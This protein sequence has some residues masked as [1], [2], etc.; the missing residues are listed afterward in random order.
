[1]IVLT[2]AVSCYIV[3]RQ[4]IMGGDDVISD[5][6]AFLRRLQEMKREGRRDNDLELENRQIKE[7]F[8]HQVHPTEPLRKANGFGSRSQHKP[9]QIDITDLSKKILDN[10]QNVNGTSQVSQVPDLER[11]AHGYVTLPTLQDALRIFSYEDVSFDKYSL[12][13]PVSQ[14][15]PLYRPLTELRPDICMKLRYTLKNAQVSIVV[16][17][18]N[19]MWAVLLRTIHSILMRSPPDLLLEI[20]M[21]DDNSNFD[22]LR[23]PLERYTQ[24][25]PK[26][27][28]VRLRNREGLMRARMAGA[29]LARGD[30]I[31]FLDAHVEC[32]HG[33]LEPLVDRI[34]TDRNILAVPLVNSIDPNTFDYTYVPV[35]SQGTFSWELDYVWKDKLV[36]YE[37]IGVAPH[38]TATMTGCAFAV[39]KETFFRFGGFDEGMDIWGGEQIEISFR[40]WMCGGS[41]EIVPCSHV[42][43]IY[44]AHLPYAFTSGILYK[45]Q[46]RVAEVWMDDFKRYYYYTIPFNPMIFS[47]SELRSI[48]ER[49]R[50]RHKLHCKPFSWY[51]NH[52]A[53]EVEVPPT[54]ASLFGQ[55]KSVG[56]GMCVSQFTKTHFTRF[57][58]IGVDHCSLHL[59]SM[60]FTFTDSSQLVYKGMCFRLRGTGD[61]VITLALC[62]TSDAAQVWQYAPGHPTQYAGMLKGVDVRKPIGSF[63]L[64]QSN[65]TLCLSQITYSGWNILGAMD[66]GAR[67]AHQYWIFTHAL[68]YNVTFK[69]VYANK[70]WVAP[71]PCIPG[72]M[73]INKELQNFR[74]RLN[75]YVSKRTNDEWMTPCVNCSILIYIRYWMKVSILLLLWNQKKRNPKRIW[76]W[77]CW[78]SSR[79]PCC[80]V[81]SRFCGY[82]QHISLSSD[83]SLILAKVCLGW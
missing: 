52:V 36:D 82:S 25:L 17:F 56:S 70:V 27:R 41:M 21:V 54:G 73:F 29:R 18:Y 39:D 57:R 62:D 4:G 63:R 65:Y 32:N 80:E 55:M 40:T 50:L 37:N 22:N 33:W 5:D 24:H 1:M 12:N 9:M 3:L 81:V 45:N 19:E 15:L 49:K 64:K 16:P 78:C 34:V 8:P 2:S 76:Q 79:A 11:S 77:R 7:A 35:K 48:Q 83:L 72:L 6:S 13:V 75:E 44:R 38:S 51:L 58:E 30:V 71:Y 69:D 53:P 14:S 31:V 61:S 67:N 28:L 26:V 42:G 68:R 20:I 43:H 59:P 47:P 23:V 46:Q 60:T 10:T 74:P 66:C